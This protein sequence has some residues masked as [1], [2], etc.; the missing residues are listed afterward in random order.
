MQVVV[1]PLLPPIAI[2]NNGMRQSDIL[3]FRNARFDFQWT[4]PPAMAGDTMQTLIEIRSAG[5]GV[6]GFVNLSANP[7]IF[8]VP[9][10]A[11]GSVQSYRANFSSSPPGRNGICSL[12]TYS[13]RALTRR[14]T[15]SGAVYDSVWSTPQLLN[16]EFF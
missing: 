3:L 10:N 16:P 8:T 9:S 13:F 1:E 14:T 11:P 7:R 2:R 15:P 12:D 5:G 4:N 6:C